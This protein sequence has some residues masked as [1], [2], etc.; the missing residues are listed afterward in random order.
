MASRRP[1]APKLL[2]LSALG[3]RLRI[4]HLEL[5]RGI[6]ELHS[7]RKAADACNV[8]QP[9]ATKLLRDFEEMFGSPLF[10]RDRRGMRITQQ[11]EVVRRQVYILLGDLA[12]MHAEVKVFAEGGSGRVRIGFVHSLDTALLSGAVTR[13]VGA[14]PDVRLSLR[15]GATTDLLAMLAR[16]E[17]DLVFGRVLDAASARRLEMT[18]VYSESFAIVAAVDHP[19]AQAAR[20][21][22][23]DLVSA[24]WV[25]PAQGTPLRDLTDQI[26]VRRRIPTPMVSIESTS[27]HQTSRIIARSG[28]IGVLPSAI[29]DAG[30][31]L[32]ELKQLQRGLR[33]DYAPIKLIRRKDVE[34]P[35]AV[36]R[37]VEIVQQVVREREPA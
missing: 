16:N 2:A 34:Q 18:D 4:K 33:S 37:F 17:L 10:T 24:S 32:G 22:W 19:L 1:P 20:T 30:E 13:M 31:R 5:F 14:S 15:E 12:N 9:A 25:M 28:L 3:A 21:R 26:F 6:C 29:A 11:G 23:Q 8:T 36:L 35:P 7:L 27:F